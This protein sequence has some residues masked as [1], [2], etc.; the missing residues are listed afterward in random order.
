MTKNLGLMMIVL[1]TGSGCIGDAFT[2][3]EPGYGGGTTGG[4]A[5]SGGSSKDGGSSGSTGGNSGQSGK[6]GGPG[7]N[8]GDGRSAGSA[9][10]GNSGEAGSGIGG[11][12]G[13]SAGQA[14]MGGSNGEGGNASGS[15]GSSGT[16]GTG[17]FNTGGN[18]G[19][20]GGDGG[21][22]G[23]SNNG[24]ASGT[25]G[26]GGLGGDAGMGGESGAGGSG[27]DPCMAQ[28]VPD[29]LTISCTNACTKVLVFNGAIVPAK[30]SAD[31][32]ECETI[33]FTNKPAADD[34]VY[35]WVDTPNP[36]DLDMFKAVSL[37]KYPKT[38]FMKC[39][40]ASPDP[41]PAPDH[42]EMENEIF[43][44]GYITVPCGSNPQISLSQTCAFGINVIAQY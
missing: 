43:G 10:G 39:K 35:A 26:H 13:G 18:S 41:G 16:A 24:G 8:G 30:S 29:S 17:G 38:C 37:G 28:P 6:D 27:G 31:N 11:N 40:A 5:G 7:G 20:T 1:I 36:A 4:T 42:S 34:S 12:S 19:S 14:G 22:G 33:P 2:T 15:G 9:D 3:F 44:G 23:S 32:S 21:A 25:G